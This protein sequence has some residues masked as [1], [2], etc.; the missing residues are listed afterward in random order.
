MLAHH[1]HFRACHSQPF[2]D[3]SAS[4][5]PLDAQ[6]AI[7][8]LEERRAD[9]ARQLAS[10]DRDLLGMRA[11]LLA[12]QYDMRRKVPSFY[13]TESKFDV[14]TCINYAFFN[15]V[16]QCTVHG[17]PNLEYTFVFSSLPMKLNRLPHAQSA[18]VVPPNYRPPSIDDLAD[19]IRNY[20]DANA[21]RLLDSAVYVNSTTRVIHQLCLRAWF[22][23]PV[24]DKTL[25]SATIHGSPVIENCP[26]IKSISFEPT[27]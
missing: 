6:Q 8:Q 22:R 27:Q 2:M 17:P 23:I 3:I 13:I 9:L 15:V 4:S 14:V 21:G 1:A 16:L 18:L 7:E 12:T 20:I 10:I 24:T 11:A 5:A 25:P 19:E 26:T